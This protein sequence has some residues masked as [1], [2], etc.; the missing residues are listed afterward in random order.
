MQLH[1]PVVVRDQEDHQ[2]RE[3]A[4]VGPVVLVGVLEGQVRQVVQNEDEAEEQDDESAVHF[5]V[6]GGHVDSE[7]H[8]VEH[9]HKNILI[10]YEILFELVLELTE[11]SR[12]RELQQE[13]HQNIETKS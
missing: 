8:S 7:A 11:L 2:L 12:P 13:Q 5:L 10:V 4:Q 9:S 6:A 1:G 3:V